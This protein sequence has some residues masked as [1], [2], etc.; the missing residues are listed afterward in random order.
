[1]YLLPTNSFT[2]KVI[3][4]FGKCSIFPWFAV[5]CHVAVPFYPDTFMFAC[6]QGEFRVTVCIS[7]RY[8]L[9][10]QVLFVNYFTAESISMR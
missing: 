10:K 8:N 2:S 6:E 3:S 9:G 7:E 1:M 5:R 4:Y